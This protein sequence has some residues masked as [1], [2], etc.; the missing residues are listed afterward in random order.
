MDIL[1]RENVGNLLEYITQELVSEVVARA[2]KL[3]GNATCSADR[4]L[5]L[6]TCKFGEHTDSSYLMARHLNL[7]YYLHVILSGKLHQVAHLLLSVIA[8]VR[9]QQVV[10]TP[11]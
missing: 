10:L 5:T 1:R 8:L 2:K 11:T 3:V 9:H 6:M 7:G 4:H